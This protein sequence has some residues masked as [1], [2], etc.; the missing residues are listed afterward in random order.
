[1]TDDLM[2]PLETVQ[3]AMGAMELAVTVSSNLTNSLIKELILRE[4]ITPE[5]AAEIWESAANSLEAATNGV[6]RNFPTNRPLFDHA[7]NLRKLAETAR[8][9]AR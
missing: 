3:A 4:V 6:D 5:V 1:M 8:R 9:A 7:A 2:V